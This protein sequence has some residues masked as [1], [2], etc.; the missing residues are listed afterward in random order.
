MDPG[1]A[2]ADM[3]RDG[4]PL[5]I[6]VLAWC[7]TPISVE[8][9]LE[10]GTLRE[11]DNRILFQMSASD[12]SNLI[13]SPL[14]NKLGFNRA[15]AYSEEQGTIEKFRP[16]GPLPKPWLEWVKQQLSARKAER[17]KP[18]TPKAKVAPAAPAH[19]ARRDSNS[20]GRGDS[21]GYVRRR[22]RG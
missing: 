7:D 6:H 15:L 18:P 22:R 17:P 1:K 12:S 14:A 21:G 9:T 5:G 19:Q 13:D 8:R 3:L 11:F 20:C 10:R 16:Y 4:P 2:F